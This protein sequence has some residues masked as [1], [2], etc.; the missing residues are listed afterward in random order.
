[1]QNFNDTEALKISREIELRGADIYALN[2][3]LYAYG[4]RQLFF[5]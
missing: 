4:E 1:M 2:A 3:A 5:I